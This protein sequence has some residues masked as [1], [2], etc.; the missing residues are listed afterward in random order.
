MLKRLHQLGESKA[1]FAFESTLSSR[2]FAPFLKLL[3]AQGYSVAIYYFSLVRPRLA[4]RRVKLRVSMGGH[5]VPADVVK[6]RF[7]RSLNNFFA[8]YGPLADEWTMFD[9]SQ[10]PQANKLAAYL[11]NKLTVT[12]QNTWQ[13]LQKLNQAVG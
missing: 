12:E 7:K 10:S 13:K 1:D 6:R 8:L 3:K 4:V 9:N 2:T 11:E 5:H